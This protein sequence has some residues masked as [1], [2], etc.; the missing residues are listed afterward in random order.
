MELYAPP[1]TAKEAKGMNYIDVLEK[2]ENAGFTNV[3][4]NVK[5]DIVTGWLT[6]DGK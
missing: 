5:Y 2:F 1:L 3:T 6:D 4:T